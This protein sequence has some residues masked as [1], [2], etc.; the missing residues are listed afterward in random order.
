MKVFLFNRG[1]RYQDNTTLIKVL[2]SH[3]DVICLFV[4][5]PEQI[6][7]NEYFSHN[8]VGYM[9]ETL[10]ELQD[11]LRSMF[12]LP[13][14]FMEGD[15]VDTLKRIHVI[16]PISLIAFNKDYTPYARK[17]E[18]ALIEFC[19]EI[20]AEV[21]CEE[22]HL[23]HP[24]HD[25]LMRSG[26]AYKRFTPYQNHVRKLPI[27][28]ITS[29]PQLKRREAQIRRLSNV[30]DLHKFYTDNPDRLVRGGRRAAEKR[31]D[32]LHRLGSYQDSRQTLSASTSLLSADLAFGVLSVREVYW[33]IVQLFGPEHGLIEQLR[34]R[35]FFTA[36]TY[37][38]PHVLT[39]SFQPVF[40]R[41]QWNNDPDMFERW[42]QGMTGF[43]SVD[44]G[45]RQLLREGY[46]HNR[47]RM[48]VSSFLVKHMLINW[49]YGEKHFARHL[50]DIYFPSNNGNWQWTFGGLDPSFFRVFNPLTQGKKH[51]PLCVYIKK[52]IPE[53]HDVP[54]DHIHRWD[55]CHSLYPDVDYPAPCLDLKLAREEFFTRIRHVFQKN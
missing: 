17:R 51:D 18:Q 12:G 32:E 1:L 25:G 46:M 4:F 38:Y 14:E 48:I 30:L 5:T 7:D 2:Q 27:R 22:D 40:D 42:C 36:V 24:I 39:S 37:Y 28:T 29:F 6:M 20:E 21:V 8:A 3:Q 11:D 52:Y 35:D 31:L 26:T 49:R 13:L 33:R 23:L 19:S 44:A 41:M 9:I 50:T 15:V 54:A 45:M 47:A 34:W 16:E 43:P 53:L 55:V 10:M